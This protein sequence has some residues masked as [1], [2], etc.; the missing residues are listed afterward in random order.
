MSFVFIGCEK[1]ENQSTPIDPV[2]YIIEGKWVSELYPNTMYIFE[3]GLR[4]TIYCTTPNCDWDTVTTASALPN[5]ENYTFENDTL[6]IDLG[7]GNSILDFM[8]FVCDGEVV[9][10]EYDAGQYVRW[11]R[12]SYDISNCNE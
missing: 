4:Y 2:V 8:D 9:K 10:R 1:E 5:P 11:S 12:P 7:F 3:N 6:K